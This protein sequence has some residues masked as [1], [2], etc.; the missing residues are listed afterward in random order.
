MLVANP[1]MPMERLSAEDQLMLWPD[2]IWP[3]DIG[4]LAVLDGSDASSAGLSR[5]SYTPS[6]PCG[7]W[8]PAWPAMRELL[9][10]RPLL[11]TSLHHLVGPDGNLALVRS[12]LNLIKEVAHASA[13]RADVS[14]GQ[15]GCAPAMTPSGGGAP[16]DHR[17]GE[18]KPSARLAIA[19]SIATP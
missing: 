7:T 8:W 12:G 11:A 15:A 19:R 5:G 6:P 1:G 2:E 13:C 3:R 9:A 10:E 4:A 16:P 17:C 18:S 14:R